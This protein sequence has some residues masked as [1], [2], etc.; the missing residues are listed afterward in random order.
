MEGY[1]DNNP[2]H[3]VIKGFM[4]QTGDPTGTGTGGESAFGRPFR[5]EFHSRLRF[6]HRG[7]VACAHGGDR[8]SNGSQFFITLDRTPWLDKKHTIF[9]RVQGDTVYN[10]ARLGD[11]ETDEQ[12]RPEGEPPA[13]LGVSDPAARGPAPAARG[14][15][16][17][18]GPPGAQG[19]PSLPPPARRAGPPPRPP[20]PRPPGP[21]PQAEIV[22]NPFDD[23][24]PRTTKE[25][26]AR[27]EAEAR[28]REERR[29]REERKRSAP[30][31]AALLS[32][33]DDEGAGVVEAF[34]GA[35]R[36]PPPAARHPA[37][38]A[39]HPAPAT[40]HPPPATLPPAARCRG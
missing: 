35:T 12:D 22:W 37:P 11:V 28:E 2:F 33:G 25:Q 14:P 10:L 17:A 9:G 30:R 23:I 19:P 13:V 34:G 36:H 3:R 26:R 29:A 31:N 40:R 8:D 5:D 38:A 4:V 21:R 15:A 27:E 24:V 18:R 6:T 7:L 39:R 20:T 1:Y 16:P 32:F